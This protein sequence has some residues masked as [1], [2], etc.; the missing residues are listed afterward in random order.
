MSPNWTIS[1]APIFFFSFIL[2]RW[3]LKEDFEFLKEDVINGL[4]NYKCF[5]CSEYTPPILIPF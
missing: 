1:N 3:D 5:R 4:N 2:E